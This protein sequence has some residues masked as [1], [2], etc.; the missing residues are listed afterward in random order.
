MFR[1]LAAIALIFLTA[2]LAVTLWASMAPLALNIGS[3]AIAKVQSGTVVQTFQLPPGSVG[4]VA[5]TLP[6]ASTAG[7][8]LVAVISGATFAGIGAT[9]PLGWVRLA[10]NPT[11]DW[12]EAWIYQNNPGGIQS[13]AV[14]VVSHPTFTLTYYLTISEWSNVGRVVSALDTSGI[15]SASVGTTLALTT[16][17]N[18]QA[19]GEVAISAWQQSASVT[20]A[21]VFTSPAGWTRL[22][23]NGSDATNNNHVDAEY[24]LGPASG[25]PLSLTLTSNRTTIAAAG[26]V[27]VLK[28]ATPVVNQTAFIRYGSLA[29]KLNTLDCQLIDPATVPSLGDPVALTTPTWNGRVVSLTQAD[30]VDIASGHKLITIAAT[31]STVAGLG[32]G[33]GDFGDTAVGGYILAEDGFKILQEDGIGALLQEGTRFGYRSLSVQTSQNQDG[34]VTTY[35]TLKTFEGGFAAG[36]TFKLYSANLGYTGNSFTIINVSQ[37]WIG[38]ALTGQPT[39]GFLIEFGDPYQTFQLAGGGVLTQ[40]GSTAVIQP[41]A[42]IPAGVLGYAQVAADQAGITT[43]VDLTGLSATVTV[44]SGRRIRVRGKVQ[45]TSTVANDQVG[46]IIAESGAQLDFSSETIIAN[47]NQVFV[48]CE[49]ILTPSAGVHTYNLRAQRTAPGT[50]IVTMSATPTRVAFIIAEDIGT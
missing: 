38:A 22:V 8:T 4:P 45:L 29:V 44:A 14:K 21:A 30:I 34:T 28:L 48:F 49:V 19:A 25:A 37:E 12:I 2:I 17:A 26:L 42:S 43:V 47:G 33:P 50:G 27:I 23:D 1:R 10:T 13:I 20:G 31:N 46:L 15:A 16:T 7:T 24:I 35:G 32:Q 5:G 18:V 41:G 40:V 36:Q 11:T 3:V 9:F 39:Q 6:L